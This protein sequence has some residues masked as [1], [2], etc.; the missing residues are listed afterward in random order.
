MIQDSG[1]ESSTSVAWRLH[2]ASV[3][4]HDAAAAHGG[5]YYLQLGGRSSVTK[6]V[7]QMVTIPANKTL[8]SLRFYLATTTA[9]HNDPADDILYVGMCTNDGGMPVTFQTYSNLEPSNGYVLKTIDL[10]DYVGRKIQI[11]FSG[12]NHQSPV[13][14]WKLDDVTLTVE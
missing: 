14:K 8:A 3:R 1:F 6:W 7:S 2:P 5:Q 9:D 10:S 12:S 13:T 4:V 11:C